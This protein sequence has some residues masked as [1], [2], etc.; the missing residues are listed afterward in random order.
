MPIPK[1]LTQPLS[2]RVHTQ[3]TS[4]RTSGRINCSYPFAC[5]SRVLGALVT[6]LTMLALKRHYSQASADQLD[7]ILAPTAKLLAWFTPAHP[8][9]ESG[10]GYA[11]FA[12]GIII[13]P[14]CAGVNFMIM[15][16]GL[17]ALCGVVKIR[18]I[19]RMG[20]WL[21]ISMAVAY[22]AT[23]IINTLRIYVSMVL[24]NADIYGVW[25]TIE[26]VHR[27][28]GIGLYFSA[29]WML[30]IVFQYILRFGTLSIGAKAMGLPVWLPLCWYLAGAA[31]VPLANLL[32]QQGAPLLL[33]HLLTV[34]IIAPIVWGIAVWCHR[35][36]STAWHYASFPYRSFIER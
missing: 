31:G 23:I 9:Y 27:L 17:G 13:A 12:L 34:S 25:V 32:F 19:S 21:G 8:A 16:F 3:A 36:L 33:E 26:R 18:S 24:Y 29:L 4:T 28:A 20:I 10:V 15:A 14:A 7:W 22:G 35:L 30:F 6:L 1:D 5:L 2:A 11:D